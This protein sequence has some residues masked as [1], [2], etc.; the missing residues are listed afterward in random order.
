MHIALQAKIGSIKFNKILSKLT[1]ID[2]NVRIVMANETPELPSFKMFEDEEIEPELLE[3]LRERIVDGSGTP[4]AIFHSLNEKQKRHWLYL[5][6]FDGYQ[7]WDEL[8]QVHQD[9]VLRK[10]MNYLKQYLP[11]K[12]QEEINRALN[13]L[14]NCPHRQLKFFSLSLCL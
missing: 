2:C 3:H 13:Q 6:I 14:S 12:Y 10:R 11:E 8:P 1:V 9:N 7:M 5:I 4:Y